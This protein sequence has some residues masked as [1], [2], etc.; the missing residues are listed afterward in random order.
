MDQQ[1]RNPQQIITEC[2]KVA[3]QFARTLLAEYLKEVEARLLDFSDKAKTNAQQA[4]L[5]EVLRELKKQKIEI[6]VLFLEELRNG[7][8]KFQ[9]G[10]LGGQKETREDISP[11]LSL[12][13]TDQLEVE[14]AQS[15]FARRAETR[16][17]EDLFALSQRFSMLVGGRKTAEDSNPVGPTQLANCLQQGIASLTREIK[18]II[19]CYKIFEKVTLPHLAKL[20]SDINKC[21]IGSGV[22]PN[23]RYSVAKQQA[24]ASAAGGGAASAGLASPVP[25]QPGQP[26]PPAATY[27]Q[28]LMSRGAPTSMA[29]VNAFAAPGMPASAAPAYYVPVVPRQVAA[30]IVAPN[31]ALPSAQYQQELYGAI[32]TM[33][34][35]VVRP[36]NWRKAGEA[37]TP[38]E[39]VS[40]IQHAQTVAAV[41]ADRLDDEHVAPCDTVNA[42]GAVSQQLQAEINK[43]IGK[44]VNEENANIIDLV[45]MIFE[46]MLGDNSLPDNVKAVLSYLHT[47]YLKIA[48]LDQQLFAKPEHPSRLLLNAL[49]ETGSKWVNND[50]S[51][52][53]KAFPKIKATVRRVL[54]EFTNDLKLIDELLEDI[55]EFNEKVQYNV[56]LLEQRAAQKAEGE[57]KL[58]QVK[59][60]VNRAVKQRIEGKKLPAP[61]VVLLLHPWSEYLTF[62]LLRHGE[63]SES[64]NTSLEVIDNII[65]SI[66]PKATTEDQKRLMMMQEDLQKALQ[67]A[68]DS[69]AYDQAKASRLLDAIREMQA[70]A[71]QNRATQPAPAEVRKEIESTAVGHE[72]AI[73]R[74]IQPKTPE[75]QELVEKLRIVEFGTWVDFD[76][77]NGAR[78]QRLKIAWYNA[79]TSQY[80]LVNRAGKQAAVLSAVEIARYM[81]S[82]NARI[83]SGIAKPFFERALENIFSRLQASAA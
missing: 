35:S 24:P 29:P 64:W 68:F 36:A 33:Q 30:S 42:P 37:A 14:L 72:E 81:L 9:R 73:E 54:T 28:W 79:K 2:E 4:Q 56:D 51:S 82:K 48:F 77:L 7:F 1:K 44:N 17:S 61:L 65:W 41:S 55:R 32:R 10:Q 62:I 60:L 70:I 53:F 31:T 80:M 11:N 67:Q 38:R 43:E 45:G 66:Q 3:Q 83:I 15:S 5:L 46:Y 12:M 22:L 58:S 47:P 18:I 21:L 40:I 20:Y 6:E 25:T 52:Q 16:Y 57:D 69:I 71:L 49:E 39:L 78:N 59:K 26:R 19:L 74:D 8:N 63:S 50:G 27:A 76:E 75:E 34:Q 23:L 13:A